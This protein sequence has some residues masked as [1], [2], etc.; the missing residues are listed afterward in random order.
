MTTLTDYLDAEHIHYEVLQHERAFTGINEARALGIEADEVLKTVI[1]D[2]RG[3][4]IA[5]VLPGGERLDMG[6]VRSAVDDPNATLAIEEELTLD[7]GGFELGALPPVASLL[8]IDMIVDPT[9]KD[10]GPVIFAAGTQTESVK[11]DAAE[12][13][14]FQPAR[15]EQI[16]EV[17]SEG[18]A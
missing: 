9:V 13:F 16:A 5:L 12:L 1:L 15:F 8:G 10:H 7:F 3:T 11:V 14:S 18:R 4:H 6:L 17:W 2:S